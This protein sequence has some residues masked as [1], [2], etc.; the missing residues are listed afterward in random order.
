LRREELLMDSSV[1]KDNIAV[2]LS[3]FQHEYVMS[4]WRVVSNRFKRNKLAISGLLI[5]IVLI[6]AAVFAPFVTNHERD[7]I[8]LAN[9]NAPPSTQNWLGTDDIGRDIYTRLVYGTRISLTVGLV[10]T[11]MRVIVGVIMGGIAGYYGKWVDSLIMRLADMFYSFPFLAF[12]ITFVALVGPSIYNIMLVVAILGWPGLARIVRGE[13]LSLREREFMEA[14]TALGISDMRKI[15]RHLLPNTMSAVIVS[16][17]LGLAGAILVES[18]LS[19]LGLGVAPPIPTWGNMLRAGQ[20][21]Y[22]LQNRW[23]QWLPPGLAIFIAVL[24]INLVGD[25]LRDAL[26]PRLKL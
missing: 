23:W 6:L 24:S 11:F 9:T 26:D 21:L 16:A 12:A 8:D 14:A 4:P 22:V 10:A 25:G 13:I 5:L 15:V 17:T 7:A 1:Q 20:N 18:A 19:Y 3:D 2:S